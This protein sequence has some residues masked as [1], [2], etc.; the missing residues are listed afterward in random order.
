ML[1]TALNCSWAYK[2]CVKDYAQPTLLADMP[3]ELTAYCVVMGT[4]V[5]LVQGFYLYRVGAVSK[6]WY[7]VGVYGAICVGCYGVAIYMCYY[8]ATHDQV[9]AFADI[10]NVSWIWFG[11]VLFSDLSITLAMSY[12]LIFKPKKQIGGLVETSSPIKMIVLKAVQTNALSAICQ[13]CIVAL[14][15]RW[16]TALHYT[17]FGFIETKIYIGSF[18]ATLNTRNPHGNGNFDS[19]HSK[20]GRTKGL[21]AIPSQQ[22]VHVSVRQEIAV[23]G[24][25]DG[26]SLG[27]IKA[28]FPAQGS[29]AAVSASPYHHVSFEPNTTTTQ[30]VE[31]GRFQQPGMGGY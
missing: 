28:S 18:I 15:A 10:A 16:G 31:K 23:D 24:D 6:N 8:C 5:L 14:Y 27:D 7:F 20:E 30:D 22:P 21:G 26:D 11:G 19:S 9:A 13:V 2:W 3:F 25:E 17:Y 1:D 29:L 12:Y 4:A